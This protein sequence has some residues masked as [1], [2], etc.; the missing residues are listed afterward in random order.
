MRVEGGHQRACVRSN[1]CRAS[2]RLVALLGWFA[3]AGTVL[4][5]PSGTQQ[6][7]VPPTEQAAR[8][9]ERLGILREELKKSE[10]L[11]ESLARRKAE[12]LAASD[13]A[14]ATEV[15]EQHARTVSDIAGLQ[16]ELVAVTRAQTSRAT[17]APS[18]ASAKPAALPQT[19]SAAKPASTTPWW[20]VYGKVRR[21]EPVAPISLVPAPESAAHPVSA[22]RLE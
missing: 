9:G 22:R 4:A 12:R 5:E 18:S 17:P 3:C 21:A 2:L 6:H 11:L 16:R 15:E 20:D 13:A 8:D 14:G 7:V 10:A 1:W 19:S